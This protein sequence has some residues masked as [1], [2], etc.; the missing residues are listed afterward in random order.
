MN[1][2]CNASSIIGSQF[3]L[4]L[5]ALTQ[6]TLLMRR[7]NVVFRVLASSRQRHYMIEVQFMS[8]LNSLPAYITVLTLSLKYSFIVDRFRSHLQF[9]GITTPRLLPCFQG[10]CKVPFSLLERVFLTV[11]FAV[12]PRIQQALRTIRYVMAFGF[13]S[14]MSTMFSAVQLS[15]L[16]NFFAVFFA[17]RFAFNKDLLTVRPVVFS[18]MLFYLLI[19]SFIVCLPIQDTL[20]T[21][22]NIIPMGLLPLL[23][24]VRPVVFSLFVPFTVHAKTIMTIFIARGFRKLIERFFY[25]AF[26]TSLVRKQS[27]LVDVVYSTHGKANSLS[28][29]LR[30]LTATRGQHVIKLPQQCI[31]NTH[32]KQVYANLS[33]GLGG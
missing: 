24:T 32:H 11:R 6:I 18:C 1:P 27:K 9:H 20:L 7:L 25:A 30:L 10:I 12:V 22:F 31:T 2:L 4:K 29:R 26:R 16:S 3:T 33:V 23:L 5:T 17:V 13:L 28:S 21:V 15:S 14:Y 8:R 19:M